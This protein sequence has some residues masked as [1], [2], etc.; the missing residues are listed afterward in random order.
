MAVAESLRRHRWL[1]FSVKTLLLLVLVS[2][3]AFAWMGMRLQKARRQRE[4]VATIEQLGGQVRY[5]YQEDKWD[6]PSGPEWLRDLLG[7]HV[8]DR[9]VRVEF[10]TTGVPN[11]RVTDLSFLSGI[12]HLRLLYLDRTAVRDISM[13]AD[14]KE[15]RF[16]SISHTQIGDLSPLTNLHNL[17]TIN[18]SRTNVSDLSPLAKHRLKRVWM[19]GTEVSDISALAGMDSLILLDLYKTKVSDIAPLSTAKNLETLSLNWTEVADVE[20]LVG[21]KKLKSLDVGRT[22]ITAESVVELMKVLPKCQLVRP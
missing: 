6:Q 11:D 8:F 7:R 20:P 4:A 12:D 5:E 18:F 13:L 16:L 1:S 15:L 21:L 3:V 17:E 19:R 22:S 10:S 14:K 2:S 9:V